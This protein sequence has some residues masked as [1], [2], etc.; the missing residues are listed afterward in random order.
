M[1]T[2]QTP[3]VGPLLK[4]SCLAVGMTEEKLAEMAGL[5]VR[6][7]SDL[8]RGVRQPGAIQRSLSRLTVS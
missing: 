2:T 5:S 6:G 7:S 4:L 3:N 1:I 8:E